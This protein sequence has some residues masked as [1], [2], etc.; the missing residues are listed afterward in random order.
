VKSVHPRAFPYQQIGAEFLATHRNA[1]LADDMGVGKTPQSIWGADLIGVKNLLVLCPGIGRDQW[2]REFSQWQQLPRT[3]GIITDTKTVPDTDVVI[4]SYNSL[5]AYPILKKLVGRRWDRIICDEA[6][7]LKSPDAI[8]TRVV[9]GAKCDGTKGLSATT[10]GIWLLTG[11]PFPNGPHEAWTHASALFKAAPADVHDYQQW[12]DYFCSTI[13]G[14][15]GARVMGTQNIP[16]FVQLLK[17]FILRRLL[18]DV[19]P[20]LPPERYGHVVVRPDKLPPMPELPDEIRAVIEAA[21][22]K[23]LSDNLDEAGSISEDGAAAMA[24][25]QS[26]HLSS[27]RKWTGVAKAPAV[28]ESIREDMANGLERVVIFAVHRE[29]IKILGNTIP[30]NRIINGDTPQKER[31]YIIDAFQGRVP[32]DHPRAVICQIDIASTNLTLTAA[33]DVAFAETTW[34]PKD[35]W[36]GVRRCRRIG[37]RYPVLAKIYSLQGSLDEVVGTTLARKAMQNS[38]IETQ[39]SQ[40]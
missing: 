10:D 18:D 28:A 3:V 31:Q 40:R 26:T 16:E 37:Q 19:Q 35:V 9:Y 32:H 14:T 38:E 23:L 20:D 15:W 39:L 25:V 4:S 6:H 36:Q 11:T 8:R 13:P 7:Y 12:L 33:H 17:P 2:A 5:L 22:A 34:V 27:L 21:Q 1:L 24:Y 30:N 29:V